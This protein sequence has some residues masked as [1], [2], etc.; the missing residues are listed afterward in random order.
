MMEDIED[1]Q[2]EQQAR[3]SEEN[4][5]IGGSSSGVGGHIADLSAGGESKSR[6]APQ[7]V[8]YEERSKK[9]AKSRGV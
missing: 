6:F 9:S 8:T 2:E 7:I 1:Q 3:S 5:Q 4:K